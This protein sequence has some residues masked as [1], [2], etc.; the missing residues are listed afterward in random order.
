MRREFVVKPVDGNFSLKEHIYDVLKEAIMAMN[1]YADDAQL[2]LDERQLSEQLQ[3]S[4]TPIREALARLEQEGLVRI[5][6]RKGVFILRKSV[7]EILEMITVWAALESMAARLVTER[8]TDAK[9]GSLRKL[10]ASFSQDEAKT[11]LDEYSEANIRFHRR[12]L[13]LAD[14]ALLLSTADGLFLHMR[15]IRAR[16]MA[17]GDRIARSIVDHKHIIEAIEAR[18]ADIAERL[19]REHTMKLHDHVK[20]TWVEPAEPQDAEVAEPAAG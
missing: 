4:R 3:I 8:A 1:I 7:D 15:A 9:I 13:E 17:E 18:D 20:R 16:T 6:P 2:K 11:H 14:C 5:V 12:I 10:L 19:V